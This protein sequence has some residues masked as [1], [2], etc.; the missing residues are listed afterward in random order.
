MK[1]L[2]THRKLTM[3][4]LRVDCHLKPLSYKFVPINLDVNGCVNRCVNIAITV[5]F[6][7]N[8]AQSQK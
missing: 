3:L 6:S 1:K 2:P 8:Y 5:T 7:I 4:T